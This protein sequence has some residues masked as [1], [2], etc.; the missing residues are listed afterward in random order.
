LNNSKKILFAL[1]GF[2]PEHRA[3]TEIYVLNLCRY[4]I[5]KEWEVAVLISAF[6]EKKYVFEGIPV[7]TFAIPENPDVRELNGL[8]EPHGLQGFLKK[9]LEINPSIIHFH[10]FGRAINSFHLQKVKELGYKAVFTAHL[11]SLFCV[12]G[13]YLLFN[14]EICN[15]KVQLNR[16]MACYLHDKGYSKSKSYAASYLINILFKTQ[17]KRLL[18]PSW[19]LIICRQSELERLSIYAD[20][21]I[22]IAPWIKKVFS[23]NGIQKV[24][25]VEQGIQ[26]IGQQSVVNTQH[27]GYNLIFVGRLNQ[28]KG[29]QLLLQA[30]VNLP[31][32]I[33]HLTIIGIIN[34]P[35]FREVL[36][37]KAHSLGNVTWLENLNRLQVLDEI[38]KADVLVLPSISNEMAPLVILEAFDCGKPVIGSTYPAIAD[39]VT[40]GFN[41]LLFEN[42]NSQSLQNVLQRLIDEPDLLVHLQKN[43]IA[44]RNFKEV[45]KD[46]EKIY[47]N[48]C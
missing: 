20:T 10:S 27:I 26:I 36:Y 25:L 3:G 7:F 40:D 32:Q 12:K 47:V 5:E 22:A 2:F 8:I 44:P 31:R 15:G 9:V 43:V 17:L 16:C 18:P 11:G 41:G 38:A 14:K 23:Q 19:N 42:N 45:G 1:E 29:L 46:M 34:E 35:E 4:L 24:A 6:I 28:L 21:I 13:S 33:F 37:E 30:L 39:I 48:I